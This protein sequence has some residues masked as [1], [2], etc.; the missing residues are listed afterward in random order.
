MW[1]ED[2][3][4]DLLISDILLK[5]AL[6]SD[7]VRVSTVEIDEAI[8]QQKSQIE[9]QNNVK[10]TDQQFRDAVTSQAGITWE[11]YRDQIKL[12]IGQ[13]RYLLEK[14]ADVLEEAKTPPSYQEINMFYRK[15]PE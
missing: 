9:A 2:R 11:E 3:S 5:Q 6:E 12:Q 10:L 1:T 15:N 7:N 4:L 8:E 13:Q 14:K